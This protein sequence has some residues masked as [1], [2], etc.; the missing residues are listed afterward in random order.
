MP[1]NTIAVPPL[2]PTLNREEHRAHAALRLSDS[3][4]KLLEAGHHLDRAELTTAH[5]STMAAIAA[6]D[7][8]LTAMVEV[9]S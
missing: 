7:D 8:A 4:E 3:R 9:G 6:L 2:P 5:R 1:T